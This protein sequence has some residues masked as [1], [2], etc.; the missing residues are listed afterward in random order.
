MKIHLDPTL[1]NIVPNL[2]VAI[3]HYNKI[4]V[5]QSPQM[6]KGRLQLFQELLYFDLLDKPIM[7]FDGIKEWRT[8][9]ETVQ[10]GQYQYAT[11]ELLLEQIKELNYIVPHHAAVDLNHFFSL[12]Y[13]IP[14]RIYD[15]EKI[16]GDITVNNMLTLTDTKSIL[17][18]PY[19]NETKAII[20]ESTT[21]AI[22][23]FFLR[24]SMNL[25]EAG[26][27]ATAAAKMFT[28]I[29]GGQSDI[30]LLH[31]GQFEIILN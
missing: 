27:L 17:G 18:S 7:N 11:T 9:T 6:L 12:Q 13:E 3:N 4:T 31:K 28:N 16:A 30:Y 23:L 14:I 21:E 25:E 20:T 10:K 8:V 26:Q 5:A 1:F 2:K 29:N 22:Q 24:P 15:A 19:L